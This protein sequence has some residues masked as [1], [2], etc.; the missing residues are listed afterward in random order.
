[1]KN[2]MYLCAALVAISINSRVQGMEC[3]NTECP[4][5]LENLE[6]ETQVGITCKHAYHALCTYKHLQSMNIIKKLN[7]LTDVQEILGICP[8][9]REKYRLSGN[10]CLVFYV[11]CIKELKKTDLDDRVKM[12]DQLPYPLARDTINEMT[13]GARKELFRGFN[14]DKRYALLSLLPVKDWNFFITSLDGVDQAI[15]YLLMPSELTFMEKNV[16][17]RMK[18]FT[19]LDLE[20]QRSIIQ[21][22]WQD[23]SEEESVSYIGAHFETAKKHTGN[24]AQ[25]VLGTF[26]HYVQFQFSIESKKTFLNKVGEYWS[27]IGAKNLH[28][29]IPN[30]KNPT[31]CKN[32]TSTIMSLLPTLDEKVIFLKNSW[33]TLG[34]KI[35]IPFLKDTISKHGEDITRNTWYIEDLA[36]EH[37]KVVKRSD[38]HF[39]DFYD[40]VKKIVAE[41]E[42]TLFLPLSSFIWETVSF[43]DGQKYFAHLDR[44]TQKMLMSG[45]FIRGT[46]VALFREYQKT[47]DAWWEDQPRSEKL[48]YIHSLPKNTLQLLH[49]TMT[50]DEKRKI[51][52]AAAR[53]DMIKKEYLL[54]LPR[55]TWP[56]Y[57]KQFPEIV[58]LLDLPDKIFCY[59]DA[60]RREKLLENCSPTHLRSFLRKYELLLS[61][62]E[63]EIIFCKLWENK[64]ESAST[65]L[66]GNIFTVT[67][68]F[69][70]P[71]KLFAFLGTEQKKEEEKNFKKTKNVTKK[72]YSGIK[73]GA[74]K[75]RFLGPQIVK[76][77]K[78]PALAMLQK[79]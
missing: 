18:L 11:A 74:P 58:D 47:L 7:D 8:L 45:N 66:C 36:E 57:A 15:F 70:F 37:V 56:F 2:V 72:S 29:F 43:D 19:E 61:K 3:L 32:F 46:C 53:S 35:C 10:N 62:K 71:Q 79:N 54:L 31:L 17:D 63:Q 27:S 4:Y 12:I 73:R 51:I 14:S 24:M 76:K 77:P 38:E 26:N 41:T 65:L 39:Y 64:K 78:L 50:T 33:E 6:K 23:F 48:K 13:E 34:S 59:T 60:N 25:T 69:D 42:S 9:C 22:F 28:L 30:A 75:E 68:S 49:K 20:T 67:K 5:C 40:T 1:M 55:Q 52:L 21:T 44:E 16:T